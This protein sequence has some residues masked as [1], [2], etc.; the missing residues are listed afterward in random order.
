MEKPNKI[1]Y[2]LFFIFIFWI[3]FFN[4]HAGHIKGQLLINAPDSLKTIYIVSHGWHTGIVLQKDNIP[5][6]LLPK[7]T[8][9]PDAINL[10]I[11][12]GEKDFYQNPDFSIF[13]AAK[14]AL[15][16]TASVLH[17]VGFSSPVEDYFGLS[18]IIQIDL[19]VNAFHK[20]CRFIHQTYARDSLD[21]VIEAGKGLYGNSRFFLGK[22]KYYFPKTCNVWTAQALKEA[23]FKISPLSCQKAE[24]VMERAS[25]FGKVI[26]KK[27]VNPQ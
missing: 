6:S 4:S 26:R 3:I 2:Y 11:G 16:P 1:R 14:A 9:F 27:K 10:E 20:L 19:S 5:D 23:G 8:D 22:S 18:E 15:L 21:N 7:H 17:I 13:K 25:K 24:I 12:W